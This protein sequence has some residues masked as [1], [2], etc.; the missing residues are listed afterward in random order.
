MWNSLTI[1]Y[2]SLTIIA[3]ALIVA[4]AVLAA[5]MA[6]R[7]PGGPPKGEARDDFDR[8]HHLVVTLMRV[9]ALTLLFVV[10]LWFWALDSL[11]PAI[12]GGMCL[13]SVHNIGPSSAWI[14]TGLKAAVPALL[15]YW[16]VVDREGRRR[17]D[18]ALLPHTLMLLLPLGFVA[19]ASAALDLSFLFALDLRPSPCCMTLFDGPGLATGGDGIP[20]WGWTWLFGGAVAALGLLV[21][22]QRRQAMHT[23]GRRLAI[24]VSLVVVIA[25]VL[26][27][28]TR[29]GSAIMNSP[30]HCIFCVWQRV[31]AVF[32]ATMLLGFGSWWLVARAAL[33]GALT[34]ATGEPRDAKLGA[35]YAMIAAAAVVLALLA[36]FA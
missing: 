6:S 25:L 1:A 8:H 7:W 36:R 10:P 23:I 21:L 28:H 34:A 13:A 29:F 35:P 3:C 15:V 4:G 11:V 26:A 22:G 17:D 16:L 18:E 33:A 30:H 24:L 20:D 19:L 31:P 27:L 12:E 14:A 2:V 5:R 32:A 9:G